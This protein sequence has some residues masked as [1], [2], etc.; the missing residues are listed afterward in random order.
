M[1]VIKTDAT[2]GSFDVMRRCGTA[3]FLLTYKRFAKNWTIREKY[4]SYTLV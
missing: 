2:Q 3:F 4:I 1:L